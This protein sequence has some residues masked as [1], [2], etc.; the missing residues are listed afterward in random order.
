MAVSKQRR[1]MPILALTDRP[2]TSRRICLYWGVTPL[3]T[4]VVHALPRDILAAVV[5][6]GLGQGVL[7]SGSRL[8]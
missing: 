8:V 3:L 6:W 1:R 2:E 4:D 5:E 7:R